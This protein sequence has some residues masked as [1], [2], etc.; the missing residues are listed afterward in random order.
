MFFKEELNREW[1]L[2]DRDVILF[3]LLNVNT[4]K[5]PAA[6]KFSFLIVD[7]VAVY[8]LLVAKNQWMQ[9]VLSSV[10]D[11]L[12]AWDNILPHPTLISVQMSHPAGSIAKGSC[13]QDD[14]G[15]WWWRC[16][17][18]HP[19][20]SFSVGGRVLLCEPHT[21]T[22]RIKCAYTLVTT[23][24]CSH[25]QILLFPAVSIGGS[26][27]GSF[28]VCS[29]R[30]SHCVLLSAPLKPHD[31]RTHRRVW[32]WHSVSLMNQSIHVYS[33]TVKS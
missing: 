25:L 16:G 30:P 20:L 26:S 9:L 29:L 12:T 14:G 19:L 27:S 24:V 33:S 31:H 13:R 8:C 15:W 11:L 5:Y 1:T 17:I 7:T 4:G 2:V 10:P 28:A 18:L 22:M 6:C 21:V 3:C 32:V 23:C